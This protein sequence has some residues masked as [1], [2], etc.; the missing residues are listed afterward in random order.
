MLKEIA[1]EK[2]VEEVN[3]T[4]AKKREKKM[5]MVKLKSEEQRKEV[6]RRKSNLRGRRERICEDWTVLESKMR[7]KVERIAR[8]EERQGR[9]VNREYGK[10]RV[11]DVWF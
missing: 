2:E 1:A 6:M 7:S 11:E 4:G 3:R 10:L 8:E 5:L 9:R